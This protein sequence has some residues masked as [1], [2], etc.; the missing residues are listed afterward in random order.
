M[1]LVPMPPTEQDPEW[2]LGPAKASLGDFGKIEVPDGY[3]FSGPAGARILLSRMHNPIPPKLVGI[4]APNSGKWWIVL[5]YADIGCLKNIDLSSPIDADSVLSVVRLGLQA[6]NEMLMRQG[7]PPIT[8]VV[9]AIKPVYDA[10]QASLEWALRAETE[11]E[12]MV[13]LQAQTETQVVLNHSIRLLGRHGALDATA[14]QVQTPDQGSIP[15]KELV[16]GISFNRGERYSDYQ[17]GDKVATTSIE[18]F[19]AGTKPKT[20]MSPYVIPS[21]CAGAA[22]LLIGLVVT[23]IRLTRRSLRKEKMSRA[24]PDYEEHG[25]ALAHVVSAA[26]NGNGNQQNGR[27]RRTFDYQRYYSDMMVEVSGGAYS[28]IQTANGKHVV[29]ETNGQAVPAA[30]NG[31]NYSIIEANSELIANQVR[32]IEEQ[33]RLLQ[34]QARLIEEKT[35]LI[36]EKNQLLEKETELL[37]RNVL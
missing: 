7:M 14:V 15:L 30:A 6:Q 34:E 18:E 20:E 16:S 3:R 26:R 19:I 8:R 27:R 33:K 13:N 1:S 31:A 36:Q 25:Y 24:F 10:K 9:W 29:R 21:I 37:E 17:A 28:P 12:K 23:A 11:T 22:V 35:K 4:L 2:L 5:S 32:L